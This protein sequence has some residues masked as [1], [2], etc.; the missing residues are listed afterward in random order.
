M[1][2]ILNISN[3]ILNHSNNH[4]KIEATDFTLACSEHLPKEKLVEKA[5]DLSTN[6]L[7]KTNIKGKGLLYKNFNSQVSYL[8]NAYLVLSKAAEENEP[9]TPGAEW[10][11]DNNHVINDH[12]LSIKTLLPKKFYSALPRLVEGDFK[13]YPRIYLLAYSYIANTDGVVDFDMSHSFIDSFQANT[14][15]TIGE[16]WAFPLMLR[17]V[18]IKRLQIL[19]ALSLKIRDDRLIADTIINNIFIGNTLSG[20]EL[21]AKVVSTINENYQALEIVAA[22]LLMQLRMRGSAALLSVQW[23][24]EKCRELHIDFN[25]QTRESQK[26][27]ASNQISIGNTVTSLNSIAAIDWKVWFESLSKV[28]R[29]LNSDINSLYGKSD[30]QTRDRA[31]KVI[32]SISLKTKVAE[33]QVAE[34]VLAYTKENANHE[35]PGE[36]SVLFNLIDKGVSEFEKFINYSPTFILKIQR[37]IKLNSTLLYFLSIALISSTLVYQIARII[38]YSNYLQIIILLLSVVPITE[39]SIRIVQWLFSHLIVPKPLPKLDFSKS[40]D[41]NCSCVVAVHCMFDNKDS[42]EKAIKALEVRFI[43]NRDPQLKFCLLADFWPSMQ[44]KLQHDSELMNYA[45]ELLQKL[46]EKYDFINTEKFFILFRKRVWVETEGQYLGWERKRGKIVEFNKILTGDTN[47]T[48]ISDSETF[49]NLKA[50]RY[51]ITLDADSQLPPASARKLLSIIAHPLNQA[52]FDNDSKIVKRGYAVIQPAVSTALPSALKTKYAFYSSGDLGLDPYSSVVAETYQDLFEEG[53]YL[54]KGIYDVKAF[55]KALENRVPEQSLLSHDLFE[56]LFSRVGFASDVNLIDDTP[57]K[58]NVQAMRIHRWI[59]GDWQLLPW[60]FKRI[61]DSNNNKYNSPLS[62]I[63][64]W[65]L[66]DNLRRS[67]V[68]PCLLLTIILVGFIENINLNSFV[69]LYGLLLFAWPL[70]VTFISALINISSKYSLVV[71]A[72]ISFTRIYKNIISII[73]GIIL[74]PFEAYTAIHA[75][76]ITLYRLYISKKRLLDWQTAD[77]SERTLEQ[78][79]IS[80]VKQFAYVLIFLFTTATLSILTNTNNNQII[81]YL[82]ISWFLAPFV[83]CKLST[84]AVKKDVSISNTEKEYLQTLGFDTWMF[85][86]DHLNEQNNYLMPDNLQIVPD[87]VVASRTSPTNIGLSILSTISAYDLG[88]IPLTEVNKILNKVGSSLNKLE[89]F[90]G[91]LL[92]WYATDTLKSLPPRYVSFVDSGNFVAFLVAARS[93]YSNINFKQIIS[94]AHFEHLI[95]WLDKD[96]PNLIECNLNPEQLINNVRVYLNANTDKFDSLS[97]VLNE[98]KNFNIEIKLFLDNSQ[99]HKKYYKYVK[100]IQRFNSIFSGYEDVYSLVAWHLPWLELAAELTKNPN[101]A[102]QNQ[103]VIAKSVVSIE[104]ILT[105]RDLSFSLLSKVQHR[106]N[107]LVNDIIIGQQSELIR[108]L[109]RKVSGLLETSHGIIEENVK[110]VNLINDC[111]NKFIKEAD[112]SFLYNSKKDLFYIGYNIDHARYDGSHYDLLASEARLSSLVSVALGQVPQKHWFNLR[113]S[114]AR[115]YDQTVLLSWSGTMFEYLMPLLVARDYQGSLLDRA[116]RA[117]VKAQQNYASKRNIP[118]GVSESG[119]S[120]VDFHKNYQYKAFGVPGLGLKRGLID[121]LVVSP[122]STGMALMV[123]F[124]NSLKNLKQL[125]A[126]GARGEYGFFEAI[127]YTAERLS[128]EEQSHVA[129]SFLAHHQGMIL[130]A[131]NNVINN[132]IFQNRFHAD[133]N[134]QAFDILLHEKFPEK[135]TSVVPHQAELSRLEVE[136]EEERGRKTEIIQTAQTLYPRTRILSNS[137]YTVMIDNAGSGHSLFNGNISINRWREDAICNNYGQYFYIKDLTTDNVW[138]AS[139]QP[140]LSDAQNY[141]VIFNPDRVEFSRND[142]GILTNYQVVVATEDNLEVR[143]I[144]ITNT[145]SSDHKIELTSFAEIAMA[146]LAADM[147]HPAFS[148]MFIQSEYLEEYD[149]LLLRRR[150]RSDREKELFVFHKLTLPICWSPTSYDTARSAFIGRGRNVNNPIALEKSVL[151]NSTGLVLD[152]VAS[153]RTILEIKAGSSAEANYITGITESR[154]EAIDL[155]IKYHDL[156]S[157]TRTFEMAWSQSNVELRHPL[158]SV[159]QIMNF[160]H[161]ANCIIFNIESMRAGAEYVLKNRLSQSGFWRFGISGDLPIVLVRLSDPNEMKLAQELLLAHEY[162]RIRGIKFELVL[163]NEYPGGYFQDFLND[164]EGLIRSSVAA[165]SFEK[166]GGV[167][168]R[169]RSQLSEDEVNLLFA[170][171]SVVMEGRK[172]N[173]ANQI[174]LSNEAIPTSNHRKGIFSYLTDHEELYEPYQAPKNNLKFDNT[175]GGFSANNKE[176]NLIINKNKQTPAPWSNVIANKHFGFLVTESGAGYTWSGN[177]RENRLTPW[178]NDPVTDRPGEVIFIRDKDTGAYWCPTPKPVDIKSEF[179]VK[180]GFGFSEFTTQYKSIFSKLNISISNNEKLKFY[181]LKLTNCDYVVRSIECYFYVEWLLGIN[182]EKSQRMH[183]TS[184]DKQNNLLKVINYYNNEFAG[185]TAFISSNLKIENYTANRA[186]VLG[187]N[188][189]LSSPLFLE[190]ATISS[191]TNLIKSNRNGAELSGKTGCLLDSCGLIGV[192][193]ELEPMS[194]KEIVFILGEA[195]HEN[196]LVEFSTKYKGVEQVKQ[197]IEATVNFWEEM[198]NQVQVKTPDESLN[199]LLNGWLY[200]QNLSCRIW[201]RSGFYQSGG[202]L[203]FR[204][205]LQDSLALLW[206]KPE[207]TKEQI[208]LHASR[209]FLEGDVQHWWHP[210]TGRGVRTRISDDYLWLPY[211]T[212]RYI[213]FTSDTNILNEEV[214]FIEGPHLE[215]HQHDIYMTPNIANHKG[216]LYE[217]CIIAIDRALNFGTHGLPLMGG[218][219]WNDGM[220]EVGIEGKGESVWLAW[221]LYDILNKFVP[222]VLTRNDNYRYDLYKKKAE[223]LRNSIEQYAWDGNWYLRAFFD[224]GTP[225]GSHKN[226]ECQIDSLSQS[227]GIITEGANPERANIA[228]N[229]AYQRLVREKSKIICLLSPPFDSSKPSPGYIQGYLPGIRENGGQYTH[230]ACWLIWATALQ[231]NGN[232]AHQLFSLVNPIN[233]TDTKAGYDKYISEPYVLC[234]DVYSVEPLDGRAGWSWYTGSAAWLY[235]VTLEYILGIRISNNKLI[236]NPCI[237]ENWSEY[238][239]SLKWK[240]Y[241]FD[242]QINN[243]R[244]VCNGV[245]TIILNNTELVSKDIDL[246]KIQSN[247]NKISIE[248]G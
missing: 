200:Y 151:S 168:L 242:I 37:F 199:I 64:R 103:E 132:E 186:E 6:L 58:Y 149:A 33:E 54:G 16:L 135:I 86:S 123:D 66:F 48:F 38:D 129:Q 87:R 213:D 11:L 211:V 90:K 83:A 49:Q 210:P 142:H 8:K 28:D 5:K 198:T 179:S 15:L 93:A 201:G 147:A 45:K 245:K 77:F 170:F 100:S 247:Y 69:L 47:T 67:L 97:K 224:D 1:N 85:F 108:K 216:S 70:I 156:F 46:N 18:L 53:L 32:E 248:L 80:Y 180:H 215:P 243:P 34:K 178:T 202:A 126:Q 39:L 174:K 230:A 21:L 128:E 181:T 222:I 106:L 88:F 127:D 195:D 144:N 227:W 30:F 239:V 22:P 233:H 115:T 189:D 40:I 228:I 159:A 191:L 27:Q 140:I 41:D 125:E 71:Y 182:R 171:A 244:H 209:Q 166:N 17:L 124:R 98:I 96:R 229:N 208:L 59:R 92:N 167:Y 141:E 158:F 25:Q 109:A 104:K 120:G 204:D 218:G 107:D 238:S 121:D 225:L 240:D 160:Q 55:E 155:I 72:L 235:R 177:S 68:A 101:T 162:L 35:I 51:V 130:V 152:P 7:V 23:L 196:D 217:H 74:L 221:F 157:I 163:F 94:K 73:T 2:N 172:G 76:I 241:N 26:S 231:G 146:S 164:L 110:S 50:I 134:I 138:S 219:D 165:H 175:L 205:Q 136:Q 95:T 214:S 148:K 223:S 82:Y 131:I 12:I 13:D 194:E 105:S 79:S 122:Y 29:I 236:I 20:T 89:I 150:P 52:V 190:K 9:L 36:D 118:W 78:N 185:K 203:G 63:S 137:R 57:S 62:V 84:S 3:K 111:F 206:S 176:Y 145:T 112:F 117:A 184:F 116:S 226:K 102:D 91:H 187:R 193:I 220:N 169:S 173:L 24:E 197:S 60:I 75:I 207:W 237:P 19:T 56:G 99:N 61:P 119:Y 161:L 234:G 183:V 154:D 4:N 113:R 10:L 188:R 114:F 43:G 44:E 139:Y 212:E 133:T 232:K 14:T 65:K 246:T 42:I 81:N 192:S 31:R 143:K 153:L